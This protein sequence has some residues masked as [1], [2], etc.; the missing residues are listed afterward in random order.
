MKT[1]TAL[2]LGISGQDGSYLADFLLKKKYRVFG[3]TRDNSKRNLKRLIKLEILK[4]INFF[5][6]ED[7]SFTFI[8]KIYRKIGILDEIYFLSGETS[9]IKSIDNPIQTFDS[10]VKNLVTILEFIR[11]KKRKPKYFMPHHQKYLKTLKKIFLT[12]IQKSGPELH[13]AF[14]K[15]QVCG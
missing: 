13:M 2:I 7:I 12:K 9:P 14:Q 11:L 1:K 10:N 6:K 15:L 8:K 3:V 5:K 4:K